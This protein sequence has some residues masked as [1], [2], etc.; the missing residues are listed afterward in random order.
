MDCKR[1]PPFLFKKNLQLATATLP[2]APNYG[3]N[4]LKMRISLLILLLFGFLFTGAQVM[5]KGSVQDAQTRQPIPFALI[6]SASQSVYT[7]QNGNFSIVLQSGEA[8]IL[9]EASFYQPLSID[10]S[11]CDSLTV[12]L[13]LKDQ[14]IETVNISAYRIESKLL[15]ATG[16]VGILTGSQINRHS[17][18]ALEPALNQIPGVFMHSGSLNTNRIT[19]RGIGSRTPY[20]TTKIKAYLDDIPLTSGDG[21]TTVEDI[22]LLAISQ[23]EVVRGPTSG[24]FGSGLGGGIL[25]RTSPGNEALK[26][27]THFMSGSYGTHKEG[28]SLQ[29]NQPGRSHLLITDFLYS[30]GYRENNQYNRSNLFSYNKFEISEST[31]LSALFEM[32]DLKAYI[33]S[34]IDLATYLNN[35]EKA[36]ANWAAVRGNEDVRKLRGAVS[37]KK[38]LNETSHLSST[39]FVT[40]STNLELRPFNLLSENTFTTGGRYRYVI[41]SEKFRFQTGIESIAEWYNWSTY[42]NQRAEPVNMLTDNREIRTNI[43]YFVLANWSL[44]QKWILEP[45]VN[46]NYTRYDYTDLFTSDGD[47]SGVRRFPIITSPRLGI[48]YKGI[49]GRAIYGVAS[50][51]FSPP[52]LQETLQPDGQVNPDIVPETGWNFELGSRGR[53]ANEKLY[54]DLSVYRMLIRNLLVARRT[55]EDAFVGVNAGKTSHSGIEFDLRYQVTFGTAAQ[56]Q[57]YGNGTLARYRFEEFIDLN[58]DYSGNALTG[59]PNTLLNGGIEASHRAG[60]TGSLSVRYNSGLPLNDANS[61]FSDPYQILNLRLGKAFQLL[62]LQWR[63]TGGINNLMD[64]RYASMHLINAPS[65]GAPR[66]YYPGMPRNYFVT[67]NIA[68]VR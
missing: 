5:L 25:L 29:I 41:E 56:L 35:P 12:N 46:F 17:P 68:F 20:G 50:H 10:V 67:V 53:L 7:S 24:V 48:N 59:V 26:V 2:E 66:Y 55:G 45:G 16:A 54:Y 37:M 63:V 33:P 47:G 14:R 43:N 64:V 9:V 6:S 36:A 11:N 34:S 19:I 44:D 62:S 15:D 3:L 65:F 13:Y 8:S 21:E 28:I 27:Q 1:Q 51:G 38:K 18:V 32:V 40:H 30:D 31:S 42:R 39:T 49:P 57:F 22:S 61:I 23:V 52:T 4:F 60:W 58:M